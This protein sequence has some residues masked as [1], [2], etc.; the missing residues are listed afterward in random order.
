MGARLCVGPVVRNVDTCSGTCTDTRR[1]TQADLFRQLTST[2]VLA[3]DLTHRRVD[4]ISHHRASRWS[5]GFLRFETDRASASRMPHGL[6]LKRSFQAQPNCLIAQLFKMDCG[7][8]P[9]SCLDRVGLIVVSSRASS[10]LLGRR[11]S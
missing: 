3:Q 7:A 10:C 8:L 4:G 9:P 2:R 5:R 11:H 1:R 6:S